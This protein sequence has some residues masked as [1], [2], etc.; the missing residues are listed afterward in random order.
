[1]FTKRFALLLATVLAWTLVAVG[2]RVDLL[3]AETLKVRVVMHVGD[4]APGLPDGVTFAN[5]PVA[6]TANL[7]TINDAGQTAF[8]ARLSG[9]GVTSANQV[10]A[11]SE[12]Q[13]NLT[14]LARTGEPLPGLSPGDFVATFQSGLPN[15]SNQGTAAF[16]TSLGGAGVTGANIYALFRAAGGDAALVARTGQSIPGFPGGVQYFTRNVGDARFDASGNVY[17]SAGVAAVPSEQFGTPQAILRSNGQAMQTLAS[18]LTMSPAG[19]SMQSFTG[20]SVAPNG[21]LGLLAVLNLPLSEARRNSEVFI[22][23][24]SGLT[25]MAREGQLPPG[26]PQFTEFGQPSITTPFDHV[27]INQQG[28]VAFGSFLFNGA[29]GGSGLRYSIWTAQRNASGGVTQQVVASTNQPLALHP[30]Y[31][32]LEIEHGSTAPPNPIVMSETGDVAFHA[33]LRSQSGDEA[34]AVMANRGGVLDWVAKHGDQIPGLP[35]GTTFDM[36]RTLYGL[37]MNDAGQLAFWSDVRY[38][39]SGVLGQGIFLANADGAIEMLAATGDL[40]D[41]G[42]G[43]MRTIE[44][45]SFY[46]GST[47]GGGPRSLNNRGQVA[48][49]ARFTD[50]TQ[51][52]L[53]TVPEPS[54]AAAM[55]VAGMLLAHVV[56]LP[57]RRESA[58]GGLGKRTRKKGPGVITPTRKKGTARKKAR[59]KGTGVITPN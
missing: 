5:S 10:A 6:L 36:N 54:S 7:P 2:G 35:A 22:R 19:Q 42:A 8:F 37:A 46:G 18:P 49:R 25:S 31:L 39:D 56:R 47:A 57:S 32:L 16:A 11:Y 58:P 30:D 1:V 38:P 17:F 26:F 13:G 29:F 33:R 53:V 12:I 52:I 48:L 21:S 51:A 40:I 23:S 34:W 4:Q 20:Y 28:T 45:F 55:I 27:T 44:T 3:A 24:T 59:K 15:F 43:D 50:G 9:E 41:V 14:L